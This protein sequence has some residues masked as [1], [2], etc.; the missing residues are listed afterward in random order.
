VIDL[1]DF[2]EYEL[3]QIDPRS[4]EKAEE[5]LKRLKFDYPDLPD[6]EPTPEHDLLAL[7]WYRDAHHILSIS[8]DPDGTFHYAAIVGK[9]QIHGTGHLNTML[10]S[11][12]VRYIKWVF[13]EEKE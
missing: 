7:E 11:E 12:F 4:I 6:P 5:F 8:F 3:K 13:E 9:M 10:P 2:E 1:S